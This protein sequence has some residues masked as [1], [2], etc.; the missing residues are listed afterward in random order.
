MRIA[1]ALAALSLWGQSSSA[2][3]NNDPFA[4]TD[5]RRSARERATPP[6]ADGLNFAGVFGDDMVL[7]QGPEAAAVLFG[8]IAGDAAAV[9]ATVALTLADGAT[10]AVASRAV[11]TVRASAADGGALVWRAALA[12][13]DGPGGNFSLTAACVAGCANASAV[14]LARVTYGD[15]WFC[16]GQSNAWLVTAHSLERNESYAR[17]RDG[18]YDNI[19]MRTQ[20]RLNLSDADATWIA[21]PPPAFNPQAGPSLKSSRRVLSGV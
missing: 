6:V 18:L 3:P 5:E 9:G 7:Q 4:L 19:R 8:T 1:A 16:S 17:V 13:S 21:P 2:A 12:P 15:V 11:A 20:T 14:T 10:G